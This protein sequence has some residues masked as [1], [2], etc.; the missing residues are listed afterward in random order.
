MKKII[1]SAVSE[2]IKII[3][4]KNNSKKVAWQFILE[5]LDAALKWKSCN[6]R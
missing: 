1:D 5:E 3:D 4:S 6:T 2:L